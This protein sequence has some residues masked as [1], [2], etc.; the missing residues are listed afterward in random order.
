MECRVQLDR[1]LRPEVEEQGGSRTVH[2]V[3]YCLLY[4]TLL[5]CTVEYRQDYSRGTVGD[6][7]L[8]NGVR[9]TVF[10]GHCTTTRARMVSRSW[11]L[12]DS[13]VCPGRK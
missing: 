2:S 7:V 4:S 10:A 13:S 12:T 3:L 5:C 9:S 8:C 6:T 11:A 1:K